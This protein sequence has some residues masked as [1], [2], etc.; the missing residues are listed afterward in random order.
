MKKLIL[1]RHGQ[2]RWNLENRFTGWKD[3]DLTETGKAEAV[4]AGQL[5]IEENISFEAVHTSLLKRANHTM[6]ICLE[7]MRKQ[8]VLVRYSW[9]LNERHYGDLQGLNKAD[10]AKKYGD[11]QVLIWRR[12]YT[13]PPPKMN[14]DDKR[15]SRFEKKYAHIKSNL[16]PNG[17]CLKDTVDRFLPYWESKIVPDLAKFKGVLIVAHGNSLRALVKHLDQTSDED[18]LK[19]NIPTGVPLVYELQSNLKPI[20]HYYLGDKKDIEKKAKSV[21]EEGKS[22]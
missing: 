17:E 15:H 2:S 12:S 11:D 9:R 21:L 7:E 19:L 5:L 16:I 14:F 1:L 10:T 8:D 22:T 20:K 13:T 18:I 3:V 4:R 6:E